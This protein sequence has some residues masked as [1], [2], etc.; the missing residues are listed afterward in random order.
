CNTHTD[1]GAYWDWTEYMNR[2]TLLPAPFYTFTSS[3]QGWVTGNGMAGLTW[4]TSSNWPGIIY[5]D[6]NANDSYITSGATSFSGVTN[7]VVNVSFLPWLA[8]NPSTAHDMQFHW[9][10]TGD[11]SW[12]SSRSSPVVRYTA[13]NQWVTAN[14]NVNSPN[15]TGKT[16]SQLRLDLDTTN[17]GYRWHI[18]HVVFQTAP[19]WYFGANAEGWTTGTGMASIHWVAGSW[20]GVIY[21]DQT[22]A[23][24]RFYSP[25]MSFRGGW[26]DR[27]HVRVYPQNGTSANHDMQIFFTTS[28]DP[29]WSSAK[30][31]AVVNYTAQNAWADVYFDVGSNAAWSGSTGPTITQLRLDV[32]NVSSGTRFIIDSVTIE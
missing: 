32:D 30:S 24:G 25:A 26:N 29:T 5:G 18:N 10:T 11:S 20:P 31:S 1:P 13:T 22:G 7:T 3:A 8:S 21:A 17:S 19:R 12:S 6:Q 4:T 9:K 2:I 23:D 14:L 28:A 27:V 15:W 16:I